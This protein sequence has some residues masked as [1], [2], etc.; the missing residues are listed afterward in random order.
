MPPAQPG[1]SGHLTCWVSLGGATFL[2][3]ASVSLSENGG[4]HFLLPVP[5]RSWEDGV[6]LGRGKGA[7]DAKDG[8]PC[9]LEVLG[10][11]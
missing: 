2:A 9:K 10:G 11:G 6:L 5:K 3:W 1:R 8:A 7:W 4:D